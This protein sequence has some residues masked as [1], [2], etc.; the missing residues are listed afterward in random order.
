M[1]T[2][3]KNER[4][5]LEDVFM[6]I[7]TQSDKYK[8]LKEI[9]SLILSKQSLLSTTKLLKQAGQGLKETNFS[10][11]LLNFYKKKKNLSK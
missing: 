5:G 1:S 7:H 6:S 4:D 3:T 8:K 2:L 11:L 10:Q 9:S